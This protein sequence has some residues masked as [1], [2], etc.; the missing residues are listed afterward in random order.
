MELVSSD[1]SG[2]RREWIR[3]RIEVVLVGGGVGEGGR[4]S[5]RA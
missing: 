5:G 2:V 1:Y 4:G 3:V